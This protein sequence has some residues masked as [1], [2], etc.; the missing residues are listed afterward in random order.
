MGLERG[1]GTAL[2]VAL[3]IGMVAGGCGDGNGD[4]DGG[5][6]QPTAASDRQQVKQTFRSL[7]RDFVGGNGERYCS[8]LIAAE[9]RKVAAFGRNLG[10]GSSCEEAIAASA[11]RIRDAGVTGDFST[12]KRLSVQIDGDRAEVTVRQDG[13][14]PKQV[15]FVR[16]ADGWKIRR[17]GISADPLA[18]AA[19]EAARE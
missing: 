19:R 12:S 17:T 4:G 9:R 11:E 14:S 6:G 1:R 18:A 16:T 10:Y 5:D 13:N 3:A 2:I 8:M 15:D 7:A